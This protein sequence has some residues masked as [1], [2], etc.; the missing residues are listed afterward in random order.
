VD[1][2]ENNVFNAD[3]RND[4]DDDDA[5][6]LVVEAIDMVVCPLMLLVIEAVVAC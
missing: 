3:A 5:E 2:R 6:A 1:D 4:L